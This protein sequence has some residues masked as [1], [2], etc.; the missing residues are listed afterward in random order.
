M[1]PLDRSQTRLPYY[2]YYFK[3][4]F[5]KCSQQCKLQGHTRQ[6]IKFGFYYFFINVYPCFLL[7]LF[8]S[9]QRSVPS[10]P[11]QV[12]HLVTAQH[13]GGCCGGEHEPLVVMRS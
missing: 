2:Y 8:F 3:F 7:F 10:A 13:G 4:N 6:K 11:F 1:F 5:F 12:L 9:L